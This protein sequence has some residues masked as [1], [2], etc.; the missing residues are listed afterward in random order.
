MHEEAALLGLTQEE[1]HAFELSLRVAAAATIAIIPPGV[2]LAW[3]LARSRVRGK[4]LIDVLVSAPLV[5][6]PVV[7]GYFLLRLLG[8]NGLVGR[9]LAS[10]FG[11]HLAFS[12]EGAALAS[13]VVALP[14]LVRSARVAL[15]G[16][17]RRL[18]DAAITLGAGHMRVFFGVTLPLAM[19]GLVAGA[20]LGFARSL[21]EFGAT[22]TF[23]G[24]VAGETR[25]LPLAIYS[26]TQAPG[27]EAPAMRLAVLSVLISLA[28]LAASELLDR[29]LRARS[30]RRG[31]L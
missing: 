8:R 4:L 27:G 6:P 24:N 20:V 14:L 15:A 19:P 31:R 18:E 17:D 22:I 3:V 13:G 26:Y 7:T 28:A 5:L 25:T 30:E 23:A 12:W 9:I 10:W 16:V 1:L 21:G 2:L 29:R 11:I